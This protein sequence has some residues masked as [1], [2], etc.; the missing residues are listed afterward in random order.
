MTGLGLVT[1]ALRLI[2]VVSSGETLQA[3]AATDGLAAANRMLGSL[4]NE[5]LAIHAITGETAFT[6]TAGDATVTMGTTGDI[7]TRPQAIEAAVIRDGTSDYPVRMLTLEEFAAI[8]DKTVR[9]TYPGALYDD[10][11]YPRRTLTLYP[12]PAA[13]KQLVLFTLRE[14]TQIATLNTALSFP[15]GYEEMLIYN[16]AVRLAPEYGKV[17][18]AEVVEIARESKAVIKRQNHRENLLSVDSAL[19]RGGRRYNIHTGGCS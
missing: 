8:P 5:K 6:L 7:T 13:A 2:G 18:P 19:T 16:L 1:A 15:P 9:A 4:S 12:T 17:I 3:E 10:C 11:G 14:L